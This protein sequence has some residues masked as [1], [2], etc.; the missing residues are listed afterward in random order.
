[1]ATCPACAKK[2]GLFNKARVCEICG[3]PFC[4]KCMEWRV[5]ENTGQVPLTKSDLI[6]HY[7]CSPQ[8]FFK[9]YK[10]FISSIRPNLRINLMNSDNLGIIVEE[11]TE[12][13]CRQLLIDYRKASSR[14]IDTTRENLIPELRP[15]YKKIKKDLTGRRIKINESFENFI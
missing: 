4:D 14:T 7:F 3:K 9:L 6:D 12:D 10:I 2:I 11:E 8:C 5:M 15:L 13:K 1:M